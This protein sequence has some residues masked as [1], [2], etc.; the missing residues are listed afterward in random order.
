[1]NWLRRSFKILLIFGT[2]ILGM[3]QAQ[4]QLTVTVTNASNT[5]PNLA[6]SYSSL[7]SAI[8]GLN[9]VTAFSGP[10]TLTCSGTSE[11]AP[12]GGF[13][14]TY[15]AA[16]S[17]SNNVVING[18][19]TTIRAAAIASAG[20]AAT[21]QADA[22][23]KIVGSDNLTI[24]NF[25]ITENS[26]NTANVDLATNRMTE[27]G[28]G[29]FA[30]SVTDGAQ[31]N[32]IQNNIITMSN[33]G[34]NPY[35]NA[36]GIFST[37]A[38]A[39][40]AP[41]TA[42]LA[43]STAGTNSNNKIYGNT[44]SGVAVGV[45]FVATPVTATVQEL[46]NDVG[47]T[48]LSTGNTI[49]YGVSNSAF[50]MTYNLATTTV[51]IA[52]GV[53]FRNGAG[54]NIRFNTITN[55]AALTLTSA[56]IY[57]SAST[58]PVGVTFTNNYS[59]NTITITQN[60]LVA[61]TGID[62][63]SGIATGT[64]TCNNNRVTINHTSTTTTTAAD[65]GIKANYVAASS[66]LNFNVVR[67]N[68][69]FN[70]TATV[71]HSG[72]LTGMLLPSGTTGTPTM[73]ALGDSII[74][75]RS[76]SVPA[77]F[78]AT[79][80][81]AVI[82]I[83]GVTG[84]TTFQIGN[85]GSGN[86]NVI[87]MYE[88]PSASGTG[89]S[90]FSAAQT[91]ISVAAA[92]GIA[93][94]YIINNTIG[95]GRTFKSYAT[96][97]LIGINH[98]ATLLGGTLNIS[99]NT[100]SF[101]RSLASATGTLTGISS[102]TSTITMPGGYSISDNTILFTGS[103]VAGSAGTA[104]GIS[105]TDGLTTTTVN[106]SI[107][108][109]TINV[110]GV[111]TAGTGITF[112]YGNTVNVNNNSI[113][114]NA[115]VSGTQIAT[116][117]GIISSGTGTTTVNIY[118]NIFNALNVTSTS[119]G[120]CTIFAISTTSGPGTTN[121]YNHDVSNISS[122]AGT[123]VAT[124]GGISI[125]GGGT[126][127]TNVYKNKIFN[128][129]LSNTNVGSLI[130]PIRIT[131]GTN[132]N[133]YN[134]LISQTNA[135][136]S[137]TNPNAIIGINIT[138]TTVTS[139]INLYYN[140]LYLSST[141][142]GANFG[143][144]GIFH[145][146]NAT[147]TTSSLSLRNNIIVNNVTPTGTG[148]S[149]A[150][151]RST[152]ALTNFASS[153][154]NNL[155]FCST[156]I[157]NDG[158]NTD[159]TI[160]DYKTRVSPRESN[161]VSE[162]LVWANNSNPIGANFLQ[163]NASTPTQV[164]SG[165]VAISGFNDD[166]NTVGSRATFPLTGQTNGGGTAPDM[167]AQEMD[168]PPADLTGPS[169]VYTP[170]A[171]TT[172]TS[173]VTLTATITDASGIP[174]SGAGLPVLYWRVGNTGTFSNTTATWVSGN[175]YSF[176]FGGGV[177]ND[178]IQYYIAAQDNAATPNTSISPSAGSS[179][180]TTNPPACSTP[181]TT[182]ARYTILS[183][184]NGTYVIGGNAAG[185]ASGADYVS[186]GEA[187]A[188]V[189]PGQIK[190]IYI[191]SGGSG[192]ATAPTIT[193]TGGG[194]SGAAATAFITGGVVTRIVVTSTGSNYSSAPTVVITSA[195]GTGAVATANVSAG[196]V[197]SGPV[198]LS[199][200]SNYDGTLYEGIFPITIKDIG[201]TAT[202]TLTI[203]PASGVA[204]T[205]SGTSSNAIFD[206]N[207][208]DYT[209]INGSN[210][211]TNS[212]NLTIINY[213]TTAGAAVMEM[214]S[215]GQGLGATNN[216]IKNC[217]IANGST[218]VV[219]YGIS[220]SG[221]TAGTTG[222]DNDN[223]TIQNNNITSV[224]TGIYAI[225]T[226]ANTTGGLDNLNIIG[227]TVSFTSS[228][229]GVY[230]IRA[231]FA[232]NSTVNQN[233]IDI[234]TSTGSLAGIS[235][236]TGFINSVVNA[237]KITKVKATSMSALPINRGIVIGTGQTGSN[238]TISN[239]V[240]YNVIS[241]Y[242]TTNVGSNCTGIMIGAVGI[243]ATYSIVTGGINIY[244]NSISL[245]GT[246]DRN[247]ATLEH[248]VFIG[249]AGSSL[250]IRNNVFTNSI[251]N[252]NA[253]GTA[254]KSYAVYCQAANT[255]F[256]N[257][258][259][260]DYYVTGS[261]AALG[262][263]TT[264]RTTLTDLQT[265][266]GG[267]V[268]S[269]SVD[270]AFNANNV[271]LPQVGAP[272]L[273]VGTPISGLTTDYLGASRSLTAPSM[274]AYE[275]GGDGAAPTITYTNLTNTQASTSRTL[276]AT[277]QD[278]GLN[279]TGVDTTVFVPTIYFKK[280]TDGNSFVGNTS[281]DNGW[282]RSA[283]ASTRSPFSLTMDFSLLRSPLAGG[284]IIQYFVVAQDYAGNFAG[285][286]SLALDG[287]NVNTISTAPFTPSSYVVIGPPI[288]PGTYTIGT[289][290]ASTYPTITAAANDFSLRG[291]TGA[292]TYEL[293]DP[294]Y[295]SSTGETFP[296][297][298]A[299]SPGTSA[300]STITIRP[301][302][303]NN[304]V[305]VSSTDATAT[306]DLNGSQYLTFD[307]RPGGTG[308]FVSGTSLTINNV[309][310]TA[311][312]IRLVNEANNNRILYCDL[313]ANNTTATTATAG[314]GVVCIGGTTG[315]NG[316]DNNTI[317]FCDIHNATGGNPFMGVYGYGSATSVAA[318]NDSNYV[319][320]CNIYDFFSAA[321]AT[322]GVYVGVNNGYW[323][324]NNNRFYQTATRTLTGAVVHRAIWCT[325]NT[326]SLTSAS[327]FTINNNFI[328]GNSAAGTGMYTSTSAV[329][330][331]FLGMDI[332]VGQGAYTDVQNNTITN[333]NQTSANTGSAVL[334]GIKIANGNVN[335]GTTTGNIIGSTTANS[336]IILNTSV[337]GGG[338]IGIQTTAGPNINISNNRISG[339]EMTGTVTTAAC[340]F[341]GLALSG[342]NNLSV[343]NNVIGDATL[344]NSINSSSSA[345]TSTFAQRIHGI[346]VNPL[347]GTPVYTISNNLIA[348]MNTNYSAT[349]AQAAS[350]KGIAMLA[351]FAGTYNITNNTVRNLSSAT[352]T[353]AAGIDAGVVGI[354]VSTATTNANASL[355][356]NVIHTLRLSNTGAQSQ[357]LNGIVMVGATTGTYTIS[358]NFV[359][360]LVAGNSLTWVNGITTGL[361]NTTISNNMV[362]LGLD[363]TGASITTASMFIGIQIGNNGNHNIYY[364]TVLVSGSSVGPDSSNTYAIYSVATAGTKL[365]RNNIFANTRQ[366]GSSIG[367]HYAMTFANNVGLTLNNNNYYTLSGPLG[368]YN[369]SNAADLASWKTLVGQDAN[370]M[371]ESPV[372]VA[373]NG[374]NSA[375]DL[376]IVPGTQSLMES[377]GAAIS[378]LTTDFDGDSRPGPAGSLNGGGLSSD[379]GADEFDGSMFPIDMGVQV[380][381]SPVGSCAISGKTVTVRIKNYSLTQALNFASN[382]VTINGS[383]SGP[384]PN[385]FSPIVLSTGTL[386]I[387]ATQDVVITTNYDMSNVGTYIFDANT[388]VVGDANTSN[389]AMPSASVVITSLTAGTVRA[390]ENS[391]CR[392]TGPP[393]LNTTAVGGD[394]QWMYSTVSKTG[395]WTNVGT[396]SSSYAHSSLITASTYFMATV[397]CNSSTISAGDT[398]GV[399]VPQII[400]TVP[401]TRCGTGTVN[402]TANAGLG[403]DVNWY[404]TATATTPLY[405]GST[406][407]PSVSS[408]TNF[409]ASGVIPGFTVPTNVATSATSAHSGGGATTYA[410]TNYND[411]IIAAYGAGTWG[412]VTS[413]GW[414]EYTWNSTV[415]LT[416]VVFYKDNRP[417]TS[418]TIEYWNGSAYVPIMTGYTGTA[419]QVDSVI[420]TSAITTTKLRFNTIAG[421]NPNFREIE[422]YAG[423][424]C[425][426]TR[427][428]V[429][430]T[431]NAAPALSLNAA[432]SNICTGSS[433]TSAVNITS[434][435]NDFDTYNWTPSTGVSG[436][437]ATGF[438][439]SPS[440]ATSYV[441]NASQS[442]GQQCVNSANLS[443]TLNP[444]TQGIVSSSN[445]QY[446]GTTGKPTLTTTATGGDYQWYESTI[447]RNGPWT[448]VG[449][450]SN[451]YT[452]STNV[453]GTTY[454]RAT[455][456]CNTNSI[457]AGDTVSVMVP[458]IASTTPA[459]RCGSG[460][461][462][463]SASGSSGT[464]LKWYA[465]STGGT[466]LGTGTSFTTPNISAS[467]NYYVGAS[468]NSGGS[469]NVA[470]PTIGTATF[471]TPTAGW[472]LRFT[473][474]TTFTINT[475]DISA[476]NTAAGA[477]TMQIKVTDLSD[478]VLYTGTLYNFNV[479][480]AL[481]RYTIPV[482][483][484]VPPG[485]YKMVMT[486][487]GLSNMVRE[488]SGVTFPYNSPNGEVSITAGANGTATAQ[489]TTAYYWFYNWVIGTGCES[490]RQLVTATV[491]PIPT[492]PN[493]PSTVSK[494]GSSI[495]VSWN[496]V[497]GVTGYQLD[498][499]TDA[500]FSSIVSGYNSLSVS[501]NSKSI[502]GLLGNTSYFIRVRSVNASSCASANSSTLNETT[503]SSN[504]NVALTAFLQGMYTGGSTMTAAPF[505]A[506][507]VTSNTI[508]DTI[509]VELRTITGTLAY[510][511]VGTISTSGLANITFPG[512]AIGGSYYI[513]FKHRNSITIAS[514][515][516]VTILA[517]GTSYNFSNAITKAFG[518][519]MID[520]GNGVYLIFTGD[521][522]QDGSVDFNDY[523]NLDIASSNGVLGYDSNDLNGDASVDFND[524]PMID[525][526]SSNGIISILPY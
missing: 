373:A 8:T 203:K 4:A 283:S 399:L 302:A 133:V 120:T 368:F 77:T 295:N 6:S 324:I 215:L 394:I 319:T 76:V 382:P 31:N 309:G 341:F 151:R 53:A 298:F 488:S 273:A 102:G 340:E 323:R 404:A 100:I 372:F 24:Q 18:G 363:E 411:G 313:Q 207:G 491:N 303:G 406:Y 446:C 448:S 152:N 197:M 477:A 240:I 354:G 79:L 116:V 168:L 169:I 455:L 108:N 129:Q 74:I 413:N 355:T 449:I 513:G 140:T 350:L 61:I 339:I 171:N 192:Y 59:D 66:S 25:T 469:T 458:V 400:S 420:F 89:T 342:G 366:N 173:A 486:Y 317:S 521:I 396:N 402:L 1:M 286:P 228:V 456:T 32:T 124:I 435:P 474:N 167:G 113:S 174:T 88:V 63:G 520:D 393:T 222:A 176:T 233:T 345:S 67:L 138:S 39:H 451:S 94:L 70:I 288:A 416:K 329:A 497:S 7:A 154:N 325:P 515:N 255:A 199:M 447:S 438:T 27:F 55:V 82:G 139:N 275:N 478:V 17:A 175:T 229:T 259:Y 149:Y 359:H 98:G 337:A 348:N 343:T 183:T 483:I 365:I 346:I 162:N 443:V 270:P 408:T 294:A 496:S 410:A 85:T 159:L 226:T 465:T 480:T 104:T 419:A 232:L 335:V 429:T 93:N 409:Y 380:L 377:G 22:V 331:S 238:V 97:T 267:N 204:A 311:P 223:I 403:N 224:T 379:I 23:I 484:T 501:G 219:N 417:F 71:T 35:R 211:G 43:T 509:T 336:A 107:S 48:S 239:N 47:G 371:V 64:I 212:K 369:T 148:T 10:V 42:R 121:I 156:G 421:T 117:T 362:R 344:A 405:T 272:I 191:N 381:V 330:S 426:S 258:D 84:A 287:S 516:T 271:L 468:F 9:A 160:G 462:T 285:S 158:T 291:I 99:T 470:S 236:E 252:T 146:T 245:Y 299:N 83:S 13:V 201:Q 386:A 280:S 320:N 307:G 256:S 332:S 231:G 73:T 306:F 189:T 338:F 249:T 135:L 198:T 250:D 81:G 20:G 95:N 261:Q 293:V 279:A 56:G 300:S 292:V 499:A 125:S 274:G 392:L 194:G 184:W 290:V 170:I 164:E 119:S 58:A 444:L 208:A 131:A 54:N 428:L 485:N 92:T 126:V 301:I 278:V 52:S 80:S 132:I 519:N 308:S 185:P 179:G 506:D 349:G 105:N 178:Q 157:F 91:G 235:L 200:S 2:L 28:I 57:C 432:N 49:T 522:N 244:H 40:T 181:P 142:T 305:V 196:K 187:I 268:N 415:S 518:D 253:T 525:V 439:F 504:V 289:F 68:E 195:T 147:T 460:T 490:A 180:N 360:S 165:A 78:T 269:I 230:G 482:N 489:T 326:G 36:V 425:E 418:M 333:I 260:N 423:S 69:I 407:S 15:T 12:T 436:S 433:S 65:I 395:P 276:I 422:A 127:A 41:A 378:G 103:Q 284:D 495:D 517:N 202:N 315:A 243:G 37:S 375:V 242:A 130:S 514:A 364:N 96:G 347:A 427:S 281:A 476:L 266:F 106:K 213:S 374:T 459:A 51:S 172:N 322:A 246:V 193:F 401:S 87:T 34:A 3:S 137:V 412:W 21:G 14:I 387:G 155:F 471:I 473:A 220:I 205:I 145:T 5:T 122:G 101:D 398:V 254:S 383:V 510:S 442:T 376:H 391:F 237:N 186:I 502:T 264:A 414:I 454:Y 494:T 450:N 257:I 508:A 227:N 328:G 314:G 334:V 296:I 118:S 177:T 216:T 30:A 134:N 262:Y 390:N 463:L 90:T 498:V 352:K 150:Y 210:S 358:R 434:N 225:G 445:A 112:A 221:L 500:G 327:G 277:I 356:G 26:A 86:G 248:N 467:T 75:S 60:A 441:L 452:P 217:N 479:T 109:N 397:S 136:T 316:N 251:I 361:G 263:L 475:V 16:T 321:S 457:E 493:A 297:V 353:T 111:M 190:S 437:A 487:T 507:G 161:S 209:T 153:S 424:V 163:L 351:A 304:G 512:A 466:A 265:G 440:V 143:A 123:G 431:V 115:S 241:P 389:D 11:T 312:A 182:P 29:L 44:I 464:S 110:S 385:S 128:L 318:N 388:S 114:I 492:A 384:N 46:G 370:S 33:G 38:S 282:K 524:Y 218:A 214:T 310:T 50:D 247:A 511:S 503:P 19:N 357:R 367:V 144:T 461:V 505:N 523:P 62:F 481:A 188:D 234:E 472:G 453:S 45:Y 166:Y 526:N 72:A 141:S 430:A 206:L